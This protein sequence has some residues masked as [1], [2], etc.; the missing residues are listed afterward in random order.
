MKP[1][2]SCEISNH[3]P[4]TCSVPVFTRHSKRTG[5][6]SSASWWGRRCAC[7]NGCRVN[8]GGFEC[9]GVHWLCLVASDST[10]GKAIILSRN[11]F[12][13]RLKIQKSMGARG[14]PCSPRHGTVTVPG[15][16]PVCCLLLE[17]PRPSG[18][19]RTRAGAGPS[20]LPPPEQCQ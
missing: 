20:H 8:A 17:R 15:H 18:P 10:M 13:L 2:A 7:A 19:E 14:H 11:Y 1:R 3:S 12:E 9:W 16:P 6:K 5:L 4:S